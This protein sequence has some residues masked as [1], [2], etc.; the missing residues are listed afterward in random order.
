MLSTRSFSV[1]TLLTT[2]SGVLQYVRY[3]RM[4]ALEHP[5]R[6]PERVMVSAFYIFFFD[7]NWANCYF[8]CSIPYRIASRTGVLEH[9][10]RIP[11]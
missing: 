2:I 11:A 6:V 10:F 5:F 3:L 7:K 1:I 4:G 8:A 9:P